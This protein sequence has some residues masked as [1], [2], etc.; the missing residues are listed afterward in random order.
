MR[1]TILA[2]GLFFISISIFVNNLY[3]QS[4]RPVISQADIDTLQSREQI[5][6][7]TIQ[8]TERDLQQL[9]TLARTGGDV[10]DE[11]YFLITYAG[12]I[13]WDNKL[14]NPERWDA[15]ATLSAFSSRAEVFNLI[16]EWY[17]EEIFS[18]LSLQMRGYQLILHADMTDLQESLDR[19]FTTSERNNMIQQTM[20]FLKNRIERY[21]LSAPVIQQQGDNQ[22]YLEIF[23]NAYTLLDI[24][25]IIIGRGNLT[26][27]IMDQEATVTFNNF[28]NANPANTFNFRGELINSAII[29]PDVEIR[30]VYGKDR[31]GLAEQ[32]LNT[33]G[34]PDFI[35]IRKE[36]GLDGNH[37]RSVE[38][39]NN[40]IDGKSFVTFML[41][42]EGGEIFYRFTSANV[43][44]VLV[45]VLED[46]VISRVTIRTAIRYVVSLGGF[47]TEDAQNIAIILRSPVFPVKL[48]IINLQPI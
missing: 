29:P 31:Y 21:G 41:D 27:Q 30:G 36:V 28:Y 13:Y 42:S 40:T 7:Y 16:E 6:N 11:L 3:S 35:V 23:G 24:S 5:K 46:R 10:P 43:G 34:N 2:I 33:A 38:V 39:N 48:A 25:N 47:E 14:P 9:I 44:N 12:K 22:I 4:E 15:Q 26:F 45:I 8:R 32:R 17:R 20:I 19:S 37:I 1:K 18:R